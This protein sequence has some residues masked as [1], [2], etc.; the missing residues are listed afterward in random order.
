MLRTGISL[1]LV[2]VALGLSTQSIH[3]AGIGSKIENFPLM[4]ESGTTHNLRSY[5]GRVVVVVFWSYRCAT[6]S[7]YSQ[8]IDSLQNKYGKDRVLIFGVTAGPDETAESIRTNKNNLKVTFPV[9]LDTEGQLASTLNATHTP[10]VFILDGSGVLR[11]QGALDN[12]KILGD[13]KRMAY[14]EDAIDAILSNRPVAIPET[15]SFGCSI[16]NPSF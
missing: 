8:R 9:L 10:S 15:E 7:R 12:N 11:Y 14:A 1:L 13:P 5:S 2:Y 3:A 4:D 6:S 16:R